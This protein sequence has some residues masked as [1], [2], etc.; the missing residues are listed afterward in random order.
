LTELIISA[1]DGLPLGVREWNPQGRGAPLL[2]LPGLVRTSG[3]FESLAARYPGRRM[4]SV[5]YAGRGRS[6][7][8]RDVRR[9][10][11]EACIADVSDLCAALHVH[12]AVAVGTSFGGLLAMGLAVARPGLLRAVV[13]NDIGP[14]IADPGRDFVRRLVA[15]DPALPDVESCAA[16]L[17]QNIPDLTISSEE[18][19]QRFARLTFGPGGDGRWHPLW[20]TRIVELLDGALPDLWPLFE[21]L[22]NLP[23]LLLRGEYSTVLTADTA[24]E[25]RRR[26][27]G[28]QAVTIPESGH[29]PILEEPESIAAIDR[30][31]AR[32]E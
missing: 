19:W 5:D 6:G 20:D 26:M 31:L 24:M 16:W 30:F 2:G 28:M 11:P 29:A 17:R 4:V 22:S 32:L 12:G 10:G 13:L 7:R 21:A 8:A 18:D 9:Y 1:W 25:M 15:T 23:V 3:D 14:V 27:P